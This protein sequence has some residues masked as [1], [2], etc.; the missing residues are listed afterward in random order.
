MGV[1]QGKG[2]G[3]RKGGG[4]G[5]WRRA[6]G[7]KT[8]VC[9]RACAWRGGV[10]C[11][12]H[13]ACGVR[14]RVRLGV[15]RRGGR[16]E[17]GGQCAARGRGPWG[18]VGA[19]DPAEGWHPLLEQPPAGTASRSST[20]CHVMMMQMDIAIACSCMNHC[21]C[22]LIPAAHTTP[23]VRTTRHRMRSHVCAARPPR[24]TR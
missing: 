7:G 21:H 18:P 23:A 22:W 3:G 13:E 8:C 6:G 20:T 4:E 14:V 1:R 24:P 15:R 19:Y 2:G 11:M 17:R 9:V 5:D 12:T 10:A 16:G